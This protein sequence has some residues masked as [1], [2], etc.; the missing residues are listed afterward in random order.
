MK[1]ELKIKFI[2][3][4]FL[5]FQRFCVKEADKGDWTY[6]VTATVNTT[7]NSTVNV[8][9]QGGPRCKLQENR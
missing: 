1:F 2:I 3:V 4:F 5:L 6:N 9:E 7:L 8:T